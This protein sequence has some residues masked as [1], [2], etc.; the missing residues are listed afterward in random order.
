M[1][2]L[3]TICLICFLATPTKAHL[4]NQPILFG[5]VVETSP[6]F[7]GGIEALFKF[8]AENINFPAEI[9]CDQ[10]RTICQFVVEKD[11][12]ISNVQVVRSSGD[13][14]LDKAAVRVLSIMPKWKP[15][16]QQGKLIRTT[17]TIPINWILASSP[18]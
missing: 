8:I 5:P 15:G 1:K 11:G 2:K 12:S 3:L 7:P 13:D 14:F 16:E 17:Y 4:D 18:Q 9:V 6:E 10:C